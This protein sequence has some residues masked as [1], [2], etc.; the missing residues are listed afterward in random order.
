MFKG[1][2]MLGGMIGCDPYLLG[3]CDFPSG[4][5]SPDV[6]AERNTLQPVLGGC[7]EGK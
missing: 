1:Q 6:G 3:S 5:Q 4:A 7:G 2:L